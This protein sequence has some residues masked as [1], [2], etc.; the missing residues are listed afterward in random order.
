[1][2]KKIVKETTIE[3]EEPMENE[4]KPEIENN[5]PNFMIVGAVLLL[6]IVAVALLT[7]QGSS[8]V[9]E[10][11]KVAAVRSMF[12]KSLSATQGATK[13][14][15]SYSETINDYETKTTLVSDGNVSYIKQDTP[16]F[17]K[18]TYFLDNETIVC[19]KA[20][21]RAKGCVVAENDSAVTAHVGTLKMLLLNDNAVIQSKQATQSLIEKG[22]ISFDPETTEKTVSGVSCTNVKFTLDYSNLT[23]VDAAQYGISQNSPKIFHGSACMSKD[24][25][26]Y[27][28]TYTYSLAGRQQNNVWVLVKADLNKAQKIEVPAN[29]TENMTAFSLLSFES[30]LNGMMKTCY[31]NVDINAR[32]KCISGDALDLRYP[33]LCNLAGNRSDQCYLNLVSIGKDTSL[34]KSIGSAGLKDDCYIE[35]AGSLKNSTFC[36][37]VVNES[38]K[39][40]CENVSTSIDVPKPKVAGNNTDSN[41]TS[42]GKNS[43]NST[44]K[45]VPDYIKNL[46]ASS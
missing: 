24:G 3:K 29:L 10:N 12:L 32:E 9:K 6:I 33:P 14:L 44:Q 15:Y 25:L 11:E 43:T 31:D 22:L 45:E 28:Q 36:S 4:E 19:S 18:E 38:K 26:I 1:M 39:P 41:V 5:K 23:L 13:Y 40:Y 16:L 37:S 17:L 7:Q 42:S 8:P 30:E 35:I 21:F 27:E 20:L 34:C 2:A 46:L